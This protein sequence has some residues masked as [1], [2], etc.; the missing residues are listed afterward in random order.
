MT[1]MITSMRMKGATG[2]TGVTQ[3][4]RI[5]FLPICKYKLS[6]FIDHIVA[7]STLMFYQY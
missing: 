2:A 3:M 7:L 1:G 5:T 4:T 6:S